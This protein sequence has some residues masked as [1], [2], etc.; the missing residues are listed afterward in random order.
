MKAGSFLQLT[1]IVPVL[2]VT[3]VPI[4]ISVLIFSLRL[5]IPC[6]PIV[7]AI[8]FVDLLTH[9]VQVGAEGCETYAS[10]TFWLPE[11]SFVHRSPRVV[12]HVL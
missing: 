4:I 9:V 1:V 11:D 12:D 7:L 8:P 2:I 3:V 6:A 5:P 10:P